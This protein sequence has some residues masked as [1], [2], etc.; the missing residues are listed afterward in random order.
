MGPMVGGNNMYPVI[1]AKVALAKCREG[2]KAFGV[3]LE[4]IENGWKYDWAFKLNEDRAKKE[5]YGD[6]K[7]VGNIYAD[8]NYPGCPYCKSNSFIVCG[9]CGKLN[10]FNDE[11][12]SFTCGW[13]GMTG[14]IVEYKGEGISSSG[15]V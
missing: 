11:T 5:G 15:D 7:I 13:C 8:P 1:E 6:T 12:K 3:R 10:C 9:G 2:R 4:K 14:E